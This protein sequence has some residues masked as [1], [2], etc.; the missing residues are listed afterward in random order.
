LRLRRGLV[1]FIF[2]L[3]VKLASNRVY[4][5]VKHKEPISFICVGPAKSEAKALEGNVPARSAGFVY[6]R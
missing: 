5:D 4:V 2:A 6:R 3:A 1:P